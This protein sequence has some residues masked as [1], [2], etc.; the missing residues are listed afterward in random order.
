MVDWGDEKPMLSYRKR[1]RVRMMVGQRGLSGTV[2]RWKLDM[3]QYMPCCR[4]IA[5]F[6][7][8]EFV[9]GC[10]S[11]QRLIVMIFLFMCVVAAAAAA[12]AVSRA[13]MLLLRA[14]G[15]GSRPGCA[16]ASGVNLRL[17]RPIRELTDCCCCCSC[18]CHC[19]C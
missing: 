19:R 6:K 7:A 9:L 2:V 15:R 16:R 3:L 1:K 17:H 18:C 10:L 5:K 14:G 8:T 13:V 11:Q 12:A 4:N